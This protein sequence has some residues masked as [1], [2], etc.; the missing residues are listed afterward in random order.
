LLAA[1]K[2]AVICSNVDALNTFGSHF[3]RSYH[4][5]AFVSPSVVVV[6]V[7]RS[8]SAIAGSTYRGVVCILKNI[9]PRPR[10]CPRP[11]FR[12]YARESVTRCIDPPVVVVVVAVIVV[13]ILF[14]DERMNKVNKVNE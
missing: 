7:S 13:A 11:W 5:N 12:W 9:P 10:T 8:G 6:A 4:F 1:C 2:C 14:V 3:P